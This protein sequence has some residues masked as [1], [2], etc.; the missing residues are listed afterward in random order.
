MVEIE[1]REV[2]L[3]PKKIHA[4]Y[5]SRELFGQWIA[6]A[7]GFT[8]FFFY[9]VVIGLN[10][11]I[12]AFAFILY[13]IWNAVN[14]PL[15]GYLMERLAYRMPWE[16]KWGIRRVPWIIISAPLWLLAYLLIFLVPSSWYGTT[17]LVTD[18]Q[19][20]IFSWYLGTICLYDTFNTLYDVNVLSIYP[21]KFP[22]LN[23]RRTVQ[24][25]GTILGIIGLVLAA[26][27]PPMF[28]T[29]GV[30]ITYRNSALV[31][32]VV[33]LVLFL[34]VIPGIWENKR[35]KEIYEQR[36]QTIGEEK[37][38]SF[39]K[40][41][42]T[43]LSDRRFMMKVIF[44]FGYQI[45]GVMIQTSGF[46]ITTYLLDSPATVIT[47]LLGAMLI[48]A[49]ISVP[50]WTF[51][52]KR[53]NNNKKLGLISGWVLFFTFIP[54]I[55]VSGIELWMI[56]LLL[57]GIG[58]G[59]SWFIDPPMMG[60]VLDHL[61]VKTGKR[62]YAI[63]YGFQA[64]FIRF[65]HTFIVLTI[66]LTHIF[67]GFVEGA[68]DLATLLALSPTP[69][70]AI[71]GIRIHSAIVPAIFVLITIILFWKF[72]DLTPEKVAQNKEK[73]KDLGL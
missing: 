6:A 57:F 61:A 37:V 28:I 67:T 23:E 56:S 62:Q 65:G 27:I 58:I 15:I 48:G 64:F 13:T 36:K 18:N 52:S 21:D 68:T 44:F 59:G 43:A 24:G 5:G 3:N 4:S 7:F 53:I 66:A 46:Y 72:Y 8:V 14:D 50:I 2:Y 11:L 32:L 17:Q 22:G 63:Y 12:A 71:F 35:L 47:L 20:L 1:E 38:E 39:F 70:L 31:T 73:L 54:M 69:E 51:L 29:T 25:Y 30:A 40:T 55:F 26:I 42:K 10:T 34:A 41:T 60:D 45:S 49:L 33:G 9:E 16:K 19:W